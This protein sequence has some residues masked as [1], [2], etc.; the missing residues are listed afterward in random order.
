MTRPTPPPQREVV[1]M[2]DPEKDAKIIR[3]ETEKALYES[4]YKELLQKMLA[5]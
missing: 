1:F 4:L 3:L 2:D 5:K